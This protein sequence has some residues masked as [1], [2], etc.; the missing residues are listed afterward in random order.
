LA[1]Q[2]RIKRQIIFADTHSYGIRPTDWAINYGSV[3]G[4]LIKKDDLP[5]TSKNE[6]QNDLYPNFE[7]VWVSGTE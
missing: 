6:L 4:N 7:G 3:S 1:I 5:N 2:L